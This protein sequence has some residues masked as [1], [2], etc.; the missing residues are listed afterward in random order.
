MSL[1]NNMRQTDGG[2][3]QRSQGVI[4]NVSVEKRKH[5]IK[6]WIGPALNSDLA[7]RVLPKNIVWTRRKSEGLRTTKSRRAHTVKE[8]QIFSVLN[9]EGKEGETKY[10]FFR[11]NAFMGLSTGTIQPHAGNSGAEMR[12]AIDRQGVSN[13]PQDNCDIKVHNGDIL[14]ADAPTDT[15]DALRRARRSKNPRDGIPEDRVVAFPS[16]WD[17]VDLTKGMHQDWNKYLRQAFG[18]NEKPAFPGTP[19]MIQLIRQFVSIGAALVVASQQEGG[20]PADG[21]ALANILRELGQNDASEFSTTVRSFAEGD[22]DSAIAAML[23]PNSEEE[24][25]G[26]PIAPPGTAPVI[27]YLYGV[28]KSSLDNLM[29]Q[30]DNTLQEAGR[31]RVIGRAMQDAAFGENFNVMMFG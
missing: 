10:D 13:M 24:L 21:Q 6:P 26:Q 16:V 7:H 19:L 27:R 11:K 25:I 1:P 18:P 9:G 14:I 29:S 20:L 30:V 17:P 12:T 23:I 3:L 5:A 8:V 31:G 28:Q 4:D 15:A 22:M 2:A